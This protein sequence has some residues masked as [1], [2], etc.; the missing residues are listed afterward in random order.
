MSELGPEAREILRRGRDEDGPT[1]ADR[2]RLKRALM[3]SIAA[4]AAAAAG[5]QA[6]EAAAAAK[7]G[8]A[9]SLGAAWKGFVVLVVAGAVGAG[10]ATQ[11]APQVRKPAAAAFP[12]SA[13]DPAPVAIVPPNPEP[14]PSAS[15]RTETD[16]P[17]RALPKTTASAAA[18]SPEPDDTLLAE[19]RRLREAHGALQ[20]GDAERALALLDAETA[21]AEGQKLHEER[22]AARVF[23]LCKLGRVA[24]ANEEARR[25]LEASPRSP[26]ADRVRKA[27]QTSR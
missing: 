26:L 10:I 25:F 16:T 18:S 1:S 24:E 13:K 8:T 3:A 9:I 22:A 14:S 23:S 19:T 6:A 27:C 17:R 20:G 2:A 15:S 21:D 7:T 4:S 12:T 11:P 5:E